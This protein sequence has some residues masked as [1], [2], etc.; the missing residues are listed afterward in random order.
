M[1]Q[2]KLEL[3]E[4]GTNKLK[5]K[6]ISQPEDIVRGGNEYFNLGDV[7]LLSLAGPEINTIMKPG[8]I[9]VWTRGIAVDQ[10]EKEVVHTFKTQLARDNAKTRIEDCVRLFNEARDVR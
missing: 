9:M 3:T 2:L 8:T 5:L 1:E 4:E 7:M 10:D 6:V